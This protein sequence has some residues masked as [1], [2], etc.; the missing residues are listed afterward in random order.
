M[1][2]ST[3]QTFFQ[4]TAQRKGG[5]EKLHSTSRRSLQMCLTIHTVTIAAQTPLTFQL[6]RRVAA[7]LPACPR[8]SDGQLFQERM[9]TAGAE[10]TKTDRQ[11]PR[12]KE[13]AK[14]KS[15]GQPAAKPTNESQSRCS[16]QQRIPSVLAVRHVPFPGYLRACGRRLLAEAK[17]SGRAARA[18]SAFLCGRM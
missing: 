14:E 2:E 4:Q 9:R 6:F 11:R 18:T 15:A 7:P 8:R 17:L 13:M 3:F 16:Q 10:T 1:E 12:E 5:Y